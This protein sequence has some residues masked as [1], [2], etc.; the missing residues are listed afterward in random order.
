MRVPSRS[1]VRHTRDRQCR[2]GFSLPEMLVVLII[3]AFVMT[4]A[5]PKLSQMWDDREA[6]AAADSFV[7]AHELARV[8]A[9]R[10][11]RDAMLHIDTSQARFWVDADTNGLGHRATIGGVVSFKS[12]V[13]LATTDS[14]RCFDMRGMP[15][16]RNNCEIGG[17][18]VVFATHSQTDSMFITPLGKVVR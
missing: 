13:K 4:I 8:T 11:G 15:S 14:L 9:V 10:F 16:S 5:I 1:W 3:A 17:D 12:G 2:P 7:R 6:A 18:T